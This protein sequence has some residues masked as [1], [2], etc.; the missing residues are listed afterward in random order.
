M[1]TLIKNLYVV[2]VLIS[3]MA[4]GSS[5]DND[6]SPSPNDNQCNYQ[7]LTYVI[8]NN[9]NT[10]IPESDLQ[11]DYFPNNDGPGQPAVE[12]WDT[13]SPGSTFV[14]TRALTV[15]AIDNNPEIRINGNNLTGVVTCQRAGN[16]V[17]DELRLDIVITGGA[18][19]ELCVIIDNVIP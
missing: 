15:G 4:I 1:K 18:E 13:T 17:G 16:A 19:A 5:C 3:I 9:I 12:V 2:L 7:G 10:Q 11:T 14:V 8:N 6:S